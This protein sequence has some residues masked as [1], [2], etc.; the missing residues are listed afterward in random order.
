MVE[1]LLAAD[2]GYAGPRVPCGQGHEA[3]LVSCRDKGVD[4]VLGPVII[5]RAWYHCPQCHHG[6]APRDE[7]LGIAGQGMSP[8]LRKMHP[9]QRNLPASHLHSCLT[10]PFGRCRLVVALWLGEG[11]GAAAGPGRARAAGPRP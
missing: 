1:E 5:R 3:H 2:T 10:P 4:T 9:G 7:Q 6:L 11:N 8:G